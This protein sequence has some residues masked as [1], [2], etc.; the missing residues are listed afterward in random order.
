MESEPGKGSVFYFSVTCELPP[1]AA[2]PETMPELERTR[3]LVVS[4][5]PG[6]ASELRREISARGASTAAISPDDFDGLDCD[7]WDAVV[8]DCGAARDGGAWRGFVEKITP[9]AIPIIGL[10]D[11][12]ADA[13]A[14]LR[15]DGAFCALLSKPV[16]YDELFRTLAKVARP[17]LEGRRA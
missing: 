2:P 1:D 11:T 17:A 9:R 7:T 10:V 14:R 5:C 6:L 3:I 4:D 12:G 16:H 8:V 15:M 13:M